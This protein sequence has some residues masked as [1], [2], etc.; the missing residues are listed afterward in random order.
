LGEKLTRRG[1]FGLLGGAVAAAVVAR[2]I[3]MFA[4]KG[5]SGFRPKG[6]PVRGGKPRMGNRDGADMGVGYGPS[7]DGKLIAT[8]RMRRRSVWEL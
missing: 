4:P 3:Y 2:K 1:F 5:G 8:D 6:M 7:F